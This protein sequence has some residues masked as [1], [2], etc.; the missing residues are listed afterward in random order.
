MIR[1]RCIIPS[2]RVGKRRRLRFGAG[3]L[4]V[5]LTLGAFPNPLLGQSASGEPGQ[6]NEALT[7]AQAVAMALETH[8]AV[9]QAEAAGEVAGAR[10]R[11][12]RSSW[13]PTLAGQGSLAQHQEPMVV[14]PL[15]GFDPL[16]PP[17]FDRTLLQGAISLGY[18]L[19]DGG[20]R[21]ARIGQ[22][23]AGQRAVEAG[24][25]GARMAVATQVSAAYLG[26]LSGEEL[27]AAVLGQREAL[28]AE[29]DRVRLFLNEGKAAQ[30]DL[31]RVEA[32]LSR[33][34]AQEIS[35]RAELDLARNRLARL[36]GLDAE[37]VGRLTLVSVSPM[38]T[39]VQAREDALAAARKANPDL[40]RVREELTGAQV[41]VKEAEAAWLPK[42]EANGRYSNF[43][44]LDGGHVQ[45]WQGAL[46]VSYPLFTG[47]ARDGEQDRAVAE[48]R[49]A[50]EA[51]RLAEMNVEE[52]V[53]T[54]L[55]SVRE[56]GALREA[57]ELAAEQSAEVARIEALA[58][59]AGAGVQTDFLRAQA[60]LFQ[61]RAFL[62][63][64]RHREVLAQIELARV[65]GD[66][67]LEWIQENMETVR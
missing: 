61:A 63:Q 27:L 30:V 40:R 64:A 17:S 10:V 58:L 54:A 34:G 3:G 1:P 26:V 11:Q 42:V 62:S 25:V 51:L 12:A 66:L 29:L 14:A 6:G 67:S 47:G 52:E 2:A 60:E 24:G 35:V 36:T 43:G 57:L 45:E 31:L 15:H 65:K 38:G 5:A 53:E 33:V 41:G 39:A 7:L 23:E 4:F 55:A 21:R 22:A 59:E 50:A 20:A 16:A 48:E 49:R 46:Q 28:S 32:A 9:G 8:P 44:T 37:V 13:L 19:Y 56:A 18:T